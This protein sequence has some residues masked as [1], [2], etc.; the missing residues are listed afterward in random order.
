MIMF[1]GGLCFTLVCIILVLYAQLD[2]E[3]KRMEKEF[4]EREDK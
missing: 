4:E 1:M 3:Y 2:K